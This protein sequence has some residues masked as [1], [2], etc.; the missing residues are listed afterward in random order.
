MRE[1]TVK[2]GGR[3]AVCTALTAL[4]AVGHDTVRAARGVGSGTVAVSLP[5]LC[6]EADLRLLAWSDK[7]RVSMSLRGRRSGHGREICIDTF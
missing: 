1:T 3:G 5:L 4:R 6:D 7:S 2:N